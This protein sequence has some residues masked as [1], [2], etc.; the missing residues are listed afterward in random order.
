VVT[1]EVFEDRA[2]D[3]AGGAE[4]GYFHGDAPRI[5]LGVSFGNGGG[6]VKAGLWPQAR[7]LKSPTDGW[8]M[9]MAQ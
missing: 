7:S 6:A 8:V 1:R 9:P 2:A 3:P 4:D 5:E